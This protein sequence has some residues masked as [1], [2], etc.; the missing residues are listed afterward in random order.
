MYTSFLFTLQALFYDVA[1]GVLNFC[2][3]PDER[4]VFNIT[5][6]V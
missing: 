1:A 3:V 4:S 5:P 2:N 6:L